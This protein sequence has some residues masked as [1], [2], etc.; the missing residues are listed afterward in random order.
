MDAG[1]QRGK[2]REFSRQLAERIKAAPSLPAQPLRL[3][4]RVGADSY[5][6]DMT[7]AGEI[8]PVPDI[9]PVPW[10]QPWFRGLANVRGRL[11]GVI[12]VAQLA[13]RAPLPAEQARQLLV[14]GP[15]LKANAGMLVTRAFG[16]RNTG[17]LEVLEAPQRD[18]PPWETR[19]FRDL[20][21]T[22]LTELDLSRL[23]AS[24]TFA[25]I[26]V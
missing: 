10:T 25:H 16:L 2:L 15:T 18:A 8:V 17:E 19:C 4:L 22:L 3:A 11:I 21:G 23:V 12:D 26:G 1:K 9:A 20:D 5:L 6:L 24:E 7:A 14:F 13:G